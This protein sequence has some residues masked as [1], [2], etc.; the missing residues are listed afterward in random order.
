MFTKLRC[1]WEYRKNEKKLKKFMSWAEAKNWL[2]DLNTM[3]ELSIYLLEN[4][5]VASNEREHEIGKNTPVPVLLRSNSQ[6]SWSLTLK[7]R[8]SLSNI[9][10]I[11]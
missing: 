10:Q 3:N 8:R 9:S 1:S 4:C 5:M 2:I 7:A 11:S 6:S